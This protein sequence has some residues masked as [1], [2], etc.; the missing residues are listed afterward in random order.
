[1]DNRLK[2]IISISITFLLGCLLIL[3][4]FIMQKRNGIAVTNWALVV[5]FYLASL[6]PSMYMLAET[7]FIRYSNFFG[8]GGVGV[9]YIPFS[10]LPSLLMWLGLRSKK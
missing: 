7:V 4:F 2:E 9:F 8:H 5:D 3:T 6:I 10:V 1:M